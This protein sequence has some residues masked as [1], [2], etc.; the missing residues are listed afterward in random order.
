MTRRALVALSF[1]LAAALGAV[2]GLVYVSHVLD[3]ID[4][5]EEAMDL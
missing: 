5:A 1:V 2:G 3:Q 4:Q